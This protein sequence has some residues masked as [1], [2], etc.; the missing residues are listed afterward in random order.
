MNDILLS[1]LIPVYNAQQFINR[2]LDS[3]VK[4]K[5]YNDKIELVIINDG[6]KDSSLS[7]LQDYQ[8]RYNNINI[9]SRENKGIGPTRNELI[10]NANGKF[11]WFIDADDYVSKE[12]LSTI[13]PLLESDR[14]DMLLMSYNWLTG[15]ATKTVTYIGEYE[16]AVDLTN[17]SIYNNS[18]WTR[19]YRTS[20]V[21]DNGIRL[22]SYI[23]GEDFD[24]IFKLTPLLGRVKCIENPLYY[25]V[26]NPKSAVGS[27]DLKHRI[28]VSEDSVRC[29]ISSNEFLNEYSDIQGRAMKKHLDY[30]TLGYLYSVYRVN[31]D[32]N[33]KF[34]VFKQLVQSGVLPIISEDGNV[35][36]TIF[37][38]I[39]N[40]AFLRVPSLIVNWLALNIY[41]SAHM[42]K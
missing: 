40:N 28:K 15:A 1:I 26:F 12:A 17:K 9:I 35:K 38:T 18:L 23:M 19:V 20:V 34:R 6:S 27:V 5:C 16:Q 25:Y 21:K 33:Y 3:I 31:F 8:S 4:Q 22:N 29:I 10:D 41:D 42:H 11:F 24:F 32:L 37:T 7:I 2:C 14:Y 30:F 13:L 39:V 36:H